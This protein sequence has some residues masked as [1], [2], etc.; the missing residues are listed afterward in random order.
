MKN[1]TT[2]IE[3]LLS[4]GITS[5]KIIS[6]KTNIPLSTIKRYKRKIKENENMNNKKKKVKRGPPKENLKK[7]EDLYL[8]EPKKQYKT[9]WTWFIENNK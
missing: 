2:V 4:Q 8:Y 6:K 1:R 5:P 7:Y 3:D 9:V